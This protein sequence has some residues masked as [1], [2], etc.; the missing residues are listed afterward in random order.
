MSADSDDDEVGQTW[1]SVRSLKQAADIKTVYRSHNEDTTSPHSSL[2]S[3]VTAESAPNPVINVSPSFSNLHESYMN[4][5]DEHTQARRMVSHSRDSSASTNRMVTRRAQ[6]EVLE[7][8]QELLTAHRESD[9]LRAELAARDQQ[10][11]LQLQMIQAHH[12]RK[13][14]RSRHD[15]DELVRQ[16]PKNLL[17]KTVNQLKSEHAADIDKLCSRFEEQIEQLKL[18]HELELQSKEEEYVKSIEEVR[19]KL[20]QDAEDRETDL[21][22]LHEIQLEKLEKRHKLE[23]QQLSKTG[24]STEVTRF[25]RVPKLEIVTD[26]SPS[27]G[28]DVDRLEAEVAALRR[29]TEEQELIIKGQEAALEDLKATLSSAFRRKS[30]EPKSIHVSRIGLLDASDDL[31]NSQG[32]ESEL[33]QIISQIEYFSSSVHLDEEHLNSTQSF[34]DTLKNLKGRIEG[35]SGSQV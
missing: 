22:Q 28:H 32:L 1:I 24:R 16:Q 14:Q 29:K 19:E 20:Q 9:R 8:Q 21:I 26:F 15:L 34:S 5:R 35:I 25:R 30:P 18:E 17:E 3:S 27:E 31:G 33:K 12:E 6:E 4:L 2:N 10:H 23:I 13:M 11:S 7:L